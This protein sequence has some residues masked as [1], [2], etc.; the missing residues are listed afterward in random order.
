MSNRNI[1]YEQ[2]VQSVYSTLLKAEG[3]EGVQVQHDVELKGKSGQL[4]QIDVYWEFY[5]AGVHH[6]VAIEC[7]NYNRA[8][9]VGKAR[10]FNGV[11]S[12]VPGLIGIMATTVGY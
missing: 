11:L 8:I 4:H 5:R 10:D 12:D 1:E 3:V 6:R 2:F 7:K 9:E